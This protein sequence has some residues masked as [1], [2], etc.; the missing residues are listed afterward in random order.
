VIGRATA[1]CGK[2]N[3]AREFKR[4]FLTVFLRSVEYY[5][6]NRKESLV[7]IMLP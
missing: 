6:G 3:C 7:V 1:G 2:I 5:R 4:D